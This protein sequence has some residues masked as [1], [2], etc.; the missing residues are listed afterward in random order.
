MATT[1][2]CPLPANKNQTYHTS[3]SAANLV[4][5]VT[6]RRLNTYSEQT[7]F[8]LDIASHNQVTHLWVK[9][10]GV[11]EIT[12]MINNVTVK[13]ATRAAG[14]HAHTVMDA[15]GRDVDWYGANSDNFENWLLDLRVNAPTDPHA[16]IDEDNRPEA[17][18]TA[19]VGVTV[20]GASAKVY[21]IAALD[22]QVE[23]D[24]E[25]RFSRFDFTP[26]WRNYTT[27]Q[28]I[29][30]RL[31]GI[32]PVNSEPYRRDLEL[33]ILYLENAVH[34]P[35]LNFLYANPNFALIP[36]YTRYPHI[37]FTEA[38]LPNWEMQLRNLEETLKIHRTLSMRV[39]E[40]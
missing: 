1:R 20:S 12:V 4:K 36:E 37:I 22:S 34:Q 21:E 8:I 30:G 16:P 29:T 10:T 5:R 13:R 32:P 26:V 35:L 33:T 25:E 11:T 15:Q 7:D 38:T 39:S 27:H 28:S 3:V 19:R 40:A 17:R 18:T 14:A 31:K 9:S 24:A 2:F 23:L 6:D